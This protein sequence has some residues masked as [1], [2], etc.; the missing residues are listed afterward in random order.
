MRR[1]VWLFAVLGCGSSGGG[2]KPVDAASDG[3]APIVAPAN[4]WTWVPIEGMRCGDGS[5]TGIGVNLVDT[6]DRV[7]IYMQGGGACWDA[8]TC[9]TLKTS[10]H[11][12]GGYGQTE[13]NADIGSLSGSYLL[14]RT[15][16]NP[17]KD[18]SWIYVPYCTG[19]LHDGANV[20]MYDATHTVHHVG[21]TNMAA[22]VAR[23]AATRPN[24]DLVWLWGISAGGY[25][26]AFDW[27]LVRAAWPQAQVPALADSSPL[28]TMDASLWPIMQAAWHMT[29]P[30]TCSG[31]T[32]DLGAMPAALRAAMPAGAR[33]GLLANTRDQTISTYFNLT[34]DQLQTETLAEQAAMTASS[35][36]AA[37]LLGGTSHVLL[38]NPAAQTTGGVVLSTWFAQWATGDPAWANAGP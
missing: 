2:G 36:Q 6:T 25:G 20:A 10:V 37:Y 13:F 26:T 27:D 28:V 34:M 35:G 14:Q 19:D 12:E 31:C 7:A 17:F 30:T 8:N 33:Y 5:Q 1:L 38:S 11:I 4:T 24:A 16:M 15:A 22:L 23:V 9:F 32:T 21:R 3:G 29:F 18:A